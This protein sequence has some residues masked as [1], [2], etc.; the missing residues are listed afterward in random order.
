M[1]STTLQV[2]LLLICS[3]GLASS[4]GAQT[5]ATIAADA[6]ELTD[7]SDPGLLLDRG[8]DELVADL[9]DSTHVDRDIADTALVFSNATGGRVVVRCMAI[10]GN[11]QVLGRARTVIPGNGLRYLRASDLSGGVDFVGSA[12]CR[13]NGRTDGSVVF[14]ARSAITSL[15]VKRRYRLGVTSFKFPVVASY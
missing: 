5:L 4:A 2:L 12:V 8:S 14:L 15:D 7:E 3:L 1:Q 11:G 6:P 10:G 9:E 13:A